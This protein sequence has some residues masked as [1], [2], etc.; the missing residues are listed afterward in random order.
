MVPRVCFLYTIIYT[1]N[2]A[3]CLC[4]MVGAFG[5]E[6]E[7]SPSTLGCRVSSMESSGL[8]YVVGLAD[9]ETA[10]MSMLRS[11]VHVAKIGHWMIENTSQRVLL[12]ASQN[13]SMKQLSLTCRYPLIS[14]YIH[15]I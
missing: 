4:S 12:N 1:F 3:P 5:L 13:L 2:H 11:K 15:T 6:G 14:Y 7:C 9:T 8:L 10:D